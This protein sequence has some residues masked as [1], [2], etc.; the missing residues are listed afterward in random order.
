MNIVKILCLS[1]VFLSLTLIADEDQYQWLEKIDSEKSLQWVATQNE[2]TTSLLKK[3]KNF[4]TIYQ[5]ILSIYDSKE[6]LRYPSITGD[7]L[8]NF[9]QDANN[10]KGVW[11][12]TTLESYQQ[13][14]TK[15]EVLLDIDKLAATEQE[16]WVFKGAVGCAPQYT[17]YMIRL[18]R[19]GGDAVVMR[20]FDLEKKEFVSDGFR[21]PEAKGS[22]AWI[23][24]DTLIVS[25]NFGEGTTTTSG[26]PNVVKIWKRGQELSQATTVFTGETSDVG[27]WGSV[28]ETPQRNY[29][30]IVRAK[31]FYTYETYIIENEKPIKINL[32]DDAEVNNIFHN[33]LL[34]QLKSDWKWDK[35]TYKQGSLISIDYNDALEGKMSAEVI[36]VPTE[37]SSISSIATTKNYLLVGS[38]E[39]VRGK[40]H[41]YFIKEG[42]W[43]SERIQAPDYGSIRVVST[44]AFKDFFFYTYENFLTPTSLYLMTADKNT[45]MKSLPQFFP[46]ENYVVNQLEATSKDGT[47]VPYFIVHHKNAKKDGSNPTLLYGY[48]GFEISLRPSYSATIGSAWL[49]QGGIYVLANIRGGGEFGPKWHRAALKENRQRAYDDFIAIAEDLIAKK[50]TAAQHLGIM[51][52]S[53][54]GLLVG[55][56]FTQRPDLFNAV[57]CRVPLLDMKRFNKLLAGASW[58]GEYGNPDKP[59]EWEYIKKYSPYH[60]LSA[61]K[62]YPYVFFN[63]S[64]RDDRVHPAHARKMVAKMKGMGHKVYY[65]ENTEGGHAAATNNEQRAFSSALIYCYL[66]QQLQK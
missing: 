33:K 47:K 53:N 61:D 50:Y 23:D 66:L 4:E 51:G 18:S 64:T 21:L 32:P 27:T 38:L 55:A 9:W 12:R 1:I 10:K 16:S 6:R 52:G 19:G 17:R 54:G 62:K 34:V 65:Y 20:E 60:N 28:I 56:V 7:H 49:E 30:V 44:S 40:L 63:T 58:M 57:V 24:K 39:N 31:T 13:T 14:D 29:Q 48:G 25:T 3:N 46:G 15:W 22:V 11:Q 36:A 45:K 5:K 42:K 41:K 43:H 35:T 8:Y 26:Y 2:E 59:E 37:R